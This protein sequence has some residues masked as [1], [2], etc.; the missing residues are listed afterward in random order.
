MWQSLASVL[1]DCDGGDKTH[2]GLDDD[3]LTAVA[4]EST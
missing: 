1:P 3:K 2:G 4:A